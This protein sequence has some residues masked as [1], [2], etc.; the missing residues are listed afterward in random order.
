MDV[1]SLLD[2]LEDIRVQL[3]LEEKKE[4]IIQLRELTLR[5]DFWNDSSNAQKI[6]ESLSELKKEVENFEKL[7]KRVCDFSDLINEYKNTEPNL[8]FE[9][10]LNNEYKT[11]R[12]EVKKLR[13]LIFL[14]GKY[15][16][17]D[18][19]LSIHA[20]QG[21]TEACDWANMLMRMYMMYADKKGWKV[22]VTDLVKGTEAGISK[23][24]ME[25]SGKYAYGLLKNESGVHRLV[26][27]SP[28]NAQ[29]L[30]QTSFAGVEVLPVI[31]SDIEVNINPNDIDFFT[32]RAGGPGGQN[33]NQV[34]TKVILVHR[35]TGIQVQCASER[36]QEQNRA[37]AMRLLRAKLY[38]IELDKRREEEQKLKGEY[39]IF[40]WGNQIRNYVLHPYKL[41]KDLRTNVES[42][43]PF[44][45]LDGN[46]DEFI[47][48]E[49]KLNL[50]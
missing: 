31:E 3:K 44:Y 23:V 42:S 43:D 11:I 4:K 40:G 19:I 29:G 7:Y 50:L 46:L 35:P 22:T 21:G 6:L 16:S 13:N 48:E 9:E 38:Q 14:S 18:A 12:H 25:I 26:R 41:V 37:A 24:S 27:I 36:S 5:Q 34:H 8:E 33:V 20:G 45:V 30:R 32:S 47:D 49:I 28:F 17:S 15:D 2:E 1:E 10:F 39:K